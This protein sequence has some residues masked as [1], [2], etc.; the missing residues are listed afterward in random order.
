[1]ERNFGTHP[2]FEKE[3][4]HSLSW[5]TIKIISGGEKRLNLIS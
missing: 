4:P 5:I 1:M 2:I 3:I